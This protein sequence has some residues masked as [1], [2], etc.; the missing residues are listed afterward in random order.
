MDRSKGPR[1]RKPQPLTAAWYR[2]QAIWRHNGFFG[3]VAMMQQQLK[4]IIRSETATDTTKTIAHKMLG[5]AGEL[6]TL[7]KTRRDQ[8]KG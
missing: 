8:E 3:C 4:D 2:R 5:Y 1:K 6:Q 7:L